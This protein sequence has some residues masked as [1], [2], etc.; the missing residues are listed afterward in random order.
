MYT[1]DMSRTDGCFFDTIAVVPLHRLQAYA[2]VDMRQISA[3]ELNFRLFDPTQ[4]TSH[5]LSTAHFSLHRAILIL[6]K[7]Q[8]NW[9]PAEV[10]FQVPCFQW[11]LVSDQ[12]HS[13]HGRINDFLQ[14]NMTLE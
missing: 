9:P 14:Q 13:L 6:T 2:N 12:G 11:Q 10:D 3:D 1:I 5:R 7:D 4:T 8:V